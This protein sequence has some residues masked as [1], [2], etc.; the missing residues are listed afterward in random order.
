MS[1]TLNVVVKGAVR[2]PVLGQ[3]AE[4]VV[5]PEVFKLNQSILT[6]PVDRMMGNN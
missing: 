6:I 3:E 1:L 2:V 5:V 4:G